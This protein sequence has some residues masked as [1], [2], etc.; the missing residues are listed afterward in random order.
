MIDA[1]PKCIPSLP[2]ADR[3]ACAALRAVDLSRPVV[4]IAGSGRRR[5]SQPQIPLTVL[6]LVRQ[7]HRR[8]HHEYGA[9]GLLQDGLAHRAVQAPSH[10]PAPMCADDDAVD[11]R[12]PGIAHNL[13]RG[14]SSSE[15]GDRRHAGGR[16]MALRK[17]IQ[18][19]SERSRVRR[20]FP[21]ES[22]DFRCRKGNLDP[23]SHM[24][25]VHGGAADLGQFLRYAHGA[26]RQLREVGGQQNAFNRHDIAF[27]FATVRPTRTVP[28]RVSTRPGSRRSSSP[29]R[30]APP[31]RR[32]HPVAGAGDTDARG[33]T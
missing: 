8:W 21:Q 30:R 20:D 26:H 3:R 24:Q 4:L 18:R 31:S 5:E 25:H 16:E 19:S 27:L 13:P 23:L 12:C 2:H 10:D 7:S 17:L 32:P 33:A 1:E 9:R 11:S 22:A 6:A 14:L 29:R 15:Y 28:R